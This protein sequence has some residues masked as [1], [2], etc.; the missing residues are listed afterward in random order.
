MKDQEMK[1]KQIKLLDLNADKGEEDARLSAINRREEEYLQMAKTGKKEVPT[2]Y[3]QLAKTQL[4]TAKAN[5]SSA[6][7]QQLD[8]GFHQRNNTLDNVT[9]RTGKIIGQAAG[10]ASM[11]HQESN[12]KLTFK[13]HRDTIR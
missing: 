1:D 3:K 12:Y 11:I 6:K 7:S 5:Y 4:E 10:A 13:I 9:D 2:F 8:E